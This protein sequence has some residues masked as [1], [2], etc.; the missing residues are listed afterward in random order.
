MKKEVGIV[1]E[2]ERDEILALFERKNGL[3]ELARIL[4]ADNTEL[5]EKLVS[6]MSLTSSKFNNWW[7]RMG[8]KYGFESSP[9]GRWEID[10]NN[11]TI[12]LVTES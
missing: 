7:E 4:T 2:E 3:T 5:Y 8:N 1:T 10:F 12:Y 6:D 11:C 9:E